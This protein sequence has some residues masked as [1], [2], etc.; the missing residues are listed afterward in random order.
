MAILDRIEQRVALP[1]D[2]EALRTKKTAT[3]PLLLGGAILTIVNMITYFSN[4]MTAAGRIY[5]G[6][7]LFVLLAALLI[8]LFP[9]FWLPII[10]SVVIGVMVTSLST[11]VFSGGFQ[12]GLEATVWMML[13]PI[14]AA[15]VAGVRGSIVVVILYIA[16]IFIAAYLEPL[17]QSVAPDLSLNMRMQIA[18]GNMI[19]MGLFAF[20][21]VLFLLREV[22]RYL[23]DR[24]GA[25]ALGKSPGAGHRLRR[26]PARRRADPRR[27]DG[28][29]S[30]RRHPPRPRRPPAR[31]SRPSGST[32]DGRGPVGHE[33]RR[34]SEP[35][36]CPRSVALQDRELVA[37][38]A[39]AFRQP[40]E[41]PALQ[42]VDDQRALAVEE[43]AF[44]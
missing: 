14:S 29:Q 43:R 32:V 44:R 27:R 28:L 37:E 36:V 1:G 13:G 4:G 12:S 42:P 10:Y 8:W 35:P 33:P 39:A 40:G 17:A 26:L 16:G 15:L 5:I 21:A 38:L 18:A 31:W 11:S 20:A 3:I 6:W 22:E 19:M 25:P 41:A 7:I 30:G 9:R 34:A 23:A 2:D 24:F